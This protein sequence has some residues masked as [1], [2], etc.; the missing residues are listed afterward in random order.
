MHF[1]KL[2]V[3][4]NAMP[5]KTK[6]WQRQQ[7]VIFVGAP[8]QNTRPLKRDQKRGWLDCFIGAPWDPS[9][10]QYICIYIFSVWL[11]YTKGDQ[12]SGCR[13]IWVDYHVTSQMRSQMHISLL[14]F[15]I[16]SSRVNTFYILLQKVFKHILKNM[17]TDA[18]MSLAGNS[19]DGSQWIDE[20]SVSGRQ[21]K[22]SR[23]STYMF[24]PSLLK[25]GHP[26][27]ILPHWI[28]A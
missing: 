17:T 2:W 4:S 19:S 1:T 22:C 21:V 15:N 16:A 28:V 23:C 11:R 13:N 6:T 25:G 10:L 24:A 20:N 9:L 5:E 8:L 27:I 12:N 18:S 14:C 26:A 7:H 3:G